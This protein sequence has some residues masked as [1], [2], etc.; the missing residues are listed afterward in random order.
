MTRIKFNLAI[1]MM[2]FSGL[3]SAECPDILKHEMKKLHSS[4]K[5]NLCK[6]FENKGLTIAQAH[7]EKMLKD[8]V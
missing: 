8:H 7:V 5:I 2:L 6:T 4:K 1:I 3:A